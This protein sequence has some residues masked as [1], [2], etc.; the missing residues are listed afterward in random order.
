MDSLG[1]L[2]TFSF[3]KNLFSI[4]LFST[5]ANLPYTI[6]VYITNGTTDYNDV[7]KSFN[8]IWLVKGNHIYYIVVDI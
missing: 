7:S 2:L 6:S 3:P 4:I 1:Y 5:T 8:I